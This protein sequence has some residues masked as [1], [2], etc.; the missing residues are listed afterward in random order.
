MRRLVVRG[1]SSWLIWLVA[2]AVFITVYIASGQV[3]QQV[4]A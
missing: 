2:V 4:V 3:V 1:S